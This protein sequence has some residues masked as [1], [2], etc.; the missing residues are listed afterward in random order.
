MS[1][2]ILSMAWLGVLKHGHNHNC[3]THKR[4]VHVSRFLTTRPGH[5]KDTDLILPHS[6][7]PHIAR[8]VYCVTR[9][10]RRLRRHGD[11]ESHLNNLGG[12]PLNGW[13]SQRRLTLMSRTHA[14]AQRRDRRA[15]RTRFPSSNGPNQLFPRPHQRSRDGLHQQRT[16]RRW[17]D[18]APPR[19]RGET[20]TCTPSHLRA[21]RCANSTGDAHISR[22]AGRTS[23]RRARFRAPKGLPSMSCSWTSHPVPKRRNRRHEPRPHP[24]K[25]RRRMT[26]VMTKP[27]K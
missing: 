14:R 17:P 23:R 11:H 8:F 25:R 27:K 10:A 5:A 26:K 4:R 21:A 16:C 15:L 12:R 7:L 19:M 18:H 6:R 22:N 20:R 13:R 9:R 1:H 24:I 3:F 2:N